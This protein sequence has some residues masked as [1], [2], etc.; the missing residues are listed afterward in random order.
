MSVIEISDSKRL[1]L[2]A[3]SISE[4]Q[5]SNFKNK[6]K[7]FAEN[8]DTA[9]SNSENEEHIK[10]FI[11]D[12]LRVSFYNDMRFSINTDGNI[13]SAIKENGVLL[14]IMEAKA[15]QN[16]AEMI[17]PKHFNRK[18]LHEVIYYYLERAIDTSKTKAMIS[19]D[20]QIRRLIISDGYDWYLFDANDIHAITNGG[21]ENRYFQFKKG[22]TPYSDTASFYE[23]LRQ[24]FDT[25]DIEEILPYIHFNI[26]ECISKQSLLK[27]LYKV[28]S[29]NY[30]IKNQVTVHYEP[31]KLNDRFYHELLYIMGLREIDSDNKKVVEIAPEIE[32]SLSYQIIK[33]LTKKDTPDEQIN[34]I[35]YELVI[36]W[37]NRLLFIKLFEGQLISF[38]SDTPEFH[39]LDN[40]KITNFEDL[41]NLFFEVLGKKQREDTKFFNQFKEIPYLNSSLF[42]KQDVE[43]GRGDYHNGIMISEL[44]NSAIKRFSRSV[45]GKK[46]K[47]NYNLLEYIIDFLNSYNFASDE[48]NASDGTMRE[49]L[50]AA[51]LG[52]IF[53]KLNGYKDGSTYTPSEITEYLSKECLERTVIDK[54]NSAMKWKCDNLTDI[55]N[56]IDTLEQRKKI[57]DVINSITICDPAVGSGHF[58]V[59]ALNQIIAI[60]KY[61]GVLFIYNSDKLLKNCE[62]TVENDV[63]TV[64]YGDGTPFLYKRND[65]QSREIQG[66]LFN[67]K[68][69]IIEN[70]L[71]G[72]DVNKN[73]VAICQLRLWI[74]LLKNAYY[75]NGVMETL[76]NIDINI[77]DGN[78]LIYYTNFAVGEST[79]K[80]NSNEDDIYDILKDYKKYVKAYKSC[81]DKK[82]KKHITT[83]ISQIK[84][85]I[86]YSRAQVRLDKVSL[87]FENTKTLEWAI[88]FP[89]AIDEKG[90]F[91]GFDIVIGNPPYIQLQSMH[92]EANKLQRMGYSTFART[93][94]IYC[95]FYELGHKLLKPNGILAFISSNKWLRAGYGENLR[96]FLAEKTNPIILIDFSGEK[97]FP[98]VTV[99]VNILIYQKSK[100]DYATMSCITKTSEWRNNLSDYVKQNA[101]DNR[102]DNSES[103]VILSPVEQ[104]IKRKIEAIGTPL[105]E[106]NVHIYRGILTGLNE[107]FIIDGKKKDE[108]IAA[109]PKSAEIIRP[110]LRG[111]DIKRYSYDYADLYI[112][113]TFPSKHYDIENYPAVKNYLLTY[114]IE[115]LEQ[116]GKTYQVNG[117]SIKARKKTN[118]KWF[119]TQDSISYSDDFSKQKIVWGNL[120][121]SSQFAWVENDFFINAPSTMITNGSKYLLA[122]L[123]SRVIDW[124]IKKLGVTRNGG[125]FEYK[126]MFIEATPIPMPSQ[127]IIDDLEQKVDRI[128]SIRKDGGNSTNIE[129]E[130]DDIVANMFNL[131]SE[132]IDYL[133]TN[134]STN[135]I[136]SS[137]SE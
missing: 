118:N 69:I 37:T 4:E 132:E 108:L 78:S 111:R 112:I 72:V 119:E 63:L 117:Q 54:I 33:L 107:A 137:E 123:N 101:V 28:L 106:W 91:V 92:A 130:I 131:S 11:N 90:R 8:L 120:C 70:C 102:F 47:Q 76:P 121:L 126:P 60:K 15:P 62:I 26:K 100:N 97:V 7:L 89:E 3:I 74:E 64:Q 136:S 68:R 51:V 32:N 57:N 48:A 2:P 12:F 129:D 49:I 53:E 105:R 65:N 30:L 17:T 82:E 77:K 44:K 55:Y 31:H 115:R 83:M 14:A 110:I 41:E 50:D 73:A 103:W 113:A 1:V 99:D 124:Y 25:I 39:I 23:E 84:Y 125:Y 95:L 75:E 46:A 67:E 43:I 109:D 9:V 5:L 71:F 27:N 20:C 134:S 86:F 6:C 16:K 80:V 34:T 66:T 29:E 22:Q 93:G 56:K 128:M 85:N 58:L 96:K 133:F 116:T 38:N 45:L 18:A 19:T 114:G 81:S 35:V 79:I 36:T 61:I 24:R 127:D 42:E 52:L 135:C 104:S 88:E 87:L 94:D 13:D 21:I 59:S 40:E 122:M 98:S 10:N